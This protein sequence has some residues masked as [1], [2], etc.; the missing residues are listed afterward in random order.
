MDS[1]FFF[2]FFSFGVD[3]IDLVAFMDMLEHS[4]E[5]KTMQKLYSC[6]FRGVIEGW[7][8]LR[9]N[10]IEPAELDVMKFNSVVLP[11]GWKAVESLL[12]EENVFI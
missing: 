5:K 7:Y 3:R 11:C 2:L 6:A 12:L 10:S 4:D 1:F 8:K 9:S